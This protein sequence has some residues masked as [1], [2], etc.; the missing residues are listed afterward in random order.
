MYKKFE[1]QKNVTGV[2]KIISYNTAIKAW[3]EDPNTRHIKL[4]K[5]KEGF[6]KCDV[7]SM[8]DLQITKQMTAAQPANL[9]CDFTLISLKRR[10][11]ASHIIIIKPKTRP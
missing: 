7:C 10:K 2:N 9:D 11:N 4:A 8:Y 3:K 6:S 5:F 1:E